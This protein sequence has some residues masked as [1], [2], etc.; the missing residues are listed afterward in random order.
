VSNDEWE[1]PPWLFDKL[2]A[3]FHF[4]LDVAASRENHKLPRWIGQ[5]ENG[6]VAPWGKV[7]WC[8]PPYSDQMPWAKKALIET[9]KGNTTVMLCMCDTSTQFFKFCA[10]AA[11]EVRL[12]DRRVQFVGATHPARFASMIVVFRPPVRCPTMQGNA[13]ISVVSYRED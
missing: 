12:L 10:L 7:N 4:E 11:D 9:E 13:I 3:E 1:T 8:N 6:L 2:N 5:K